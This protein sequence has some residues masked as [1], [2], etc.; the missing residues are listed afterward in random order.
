MF[1]FRKGHATHC[2][3]CNSYYDSTCLQDKLPDTLSVDCNDFSNNNNE[4][5][6]TKT[7]TLCRK[8]VQMVEF[9]PDNRRRVIRECGRD[10][11]SF[12]GT[13]NLYSR[14]KIHQEVCIRYG[15]NCNEAS[16]ILVSLGVLLFG[17]TAYPIRT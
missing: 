5:D 3:E 17:A 14:G 8:I 12:Q 13:C 4:R 9:Q 7:Y 11:L 10:N 6:K 2:F 1:P 16:S 15:N